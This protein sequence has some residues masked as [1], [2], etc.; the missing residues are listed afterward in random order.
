[1]VFPEGNLQFDQGVPFSL[2]SH[3]VE[4]NLKKNK[5]P[6]RLK[7]RPNTE[8]RIIVIGN[9]KIVNRPKLLSNLK[10]GWYL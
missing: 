4:E 2:T 5:Q 3:S 10:L 9:G 7:K 6:H 1:V 8:V